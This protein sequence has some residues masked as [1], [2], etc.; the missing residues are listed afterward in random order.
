MGGRLGGCAAV[1]IEIK[2]NSVQLQLQLP[3]RTEIGNYTIAGLPNLYLQR[4]FIQ[5]YKIYFN[6]HFGYKN[7]MSALLG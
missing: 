3:A 5:I 1:L 4:F 2:A 6:H 7:N